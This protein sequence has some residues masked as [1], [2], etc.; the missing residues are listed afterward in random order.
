MLNTS[1]FNI[2]DVLII[3]IVAIVVHSLLSPVF[4]AVD[5]EG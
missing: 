5:N 2:R 4:D 1:L 3:G